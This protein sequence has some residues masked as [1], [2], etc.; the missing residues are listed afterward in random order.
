MTNYNLVW[1]IMVQYIQ[2]L[3]KCGQYGI[4]WPFIT[5]YSQVVAQYSQIWQI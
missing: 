3:A 4:S 5:K 2:L 1:T